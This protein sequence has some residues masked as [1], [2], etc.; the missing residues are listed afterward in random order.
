MFV[1]SAFKIPMPAYIMGCL[2]LNSS[3]PSISMYIF[4]NILWAINWLDKCKIR[5]SCRHSKNSSTMKKNHSNLKLV[6]SVLIF[7][8]LCSWV[9]LALAQNETIIPVNVGVVL[10]DVEYSLTREIWLSCIKMALSDF[11][12]T[13]ADYNTRLVLNTRHCKQSVVSAAAAGSH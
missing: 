11:Y 8:P 7:F 13:H 10:D 12:A 3:K 9:S 5:L 4:N 6:I 2:L 1:L